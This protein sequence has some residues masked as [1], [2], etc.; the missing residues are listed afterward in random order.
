MI[1]SRVRSPFVRALLSNCTAGPV[2][3][4]SLSTI[5]ASLLAT[6]VPSTTENSEFTPRQRTDRALARGGICAR[7][8][9][10]PTQKLG[11]HDDW[12]VSL[13]SRGAVRGLRSAR[14]CPA[15]TELPAGDALAAEGRGLHAALFRARDLRTFVLGW[16][17]GTVPA[18]RGRHASAVAPVRRRFPRARA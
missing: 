8:I 4:I 1:R 3:S 14:A 10:V 12:L 13:H 18:V 5:A 11:D 9:S 7:S 17:A 15:R 16:M 6:S 2:F